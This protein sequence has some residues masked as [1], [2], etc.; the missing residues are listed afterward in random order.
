MLKQTRNKQNN[1]KK[2]KRLDKWFSTQIGFS[3][4]ILGYLSLICVNGWCRQFFSISYIF[5]SV[6]FFLFIYFVFIERNLNNFHC[7]WI[8]RKCKL[9]VVRL[10]LQTNLLFTYWHWW[11]WGCTNV[12]IQ[13]IITNES[14]GKRPTIPMGFKWKWYFILFLFSLFLFSFA[15]HFPASHTMLIPILYPFFYI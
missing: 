2:K 10:A 9:S 7:Q 13:Q 8:D 12:Q 1:T 14:D 11:G 3:P 15:I 6:L 4:D 5:V